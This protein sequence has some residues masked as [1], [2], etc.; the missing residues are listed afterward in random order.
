MAPMIPMSNLQ[1]RVETIMARGSHKLGRIRPNNEGYY[2]QVPVAV[3]GIPTRNK[4]FY[5]ISSFHDQ[6]TNPSSSI[7][8]RLTTGMLYGEWGHPEIIG[9]QQDIALA[10][11][12]EIQEK[13][14]SHHFKSI[15]SGPT[16]E[17]GGMLIL[18]DVKPTGP[19]AESLKNNFDDPCM[20]TAFSLR[21]IT[22][23][24]DRNGYSY[25]KLKKL[26]TFDAVGT[27]GYL[28]SSKQFSPSVSLESLSSFDIDIVDV[29]TA[30]FSQAALENFTDT[31]LNEFFGCKTISIRKQIVTIAKAEEPGR[32]KG[33]K[34]LQLRSQYHDLIKE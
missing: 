26:V 32:F 10:R 6:L 14:Y 15:Q 34:A 11:L 9:L 19:Y 1:F 25:R 29:D 3:M 21:G 24:E 2:E 22:S 20:N 18:A 4:T 5:D 12:S 8:I 28:E 31:E 27:S 17:N 23:A 13:N 33:V 30:I 7:N 16:L